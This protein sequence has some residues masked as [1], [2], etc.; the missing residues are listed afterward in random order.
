MVN[1][2]V[3]ESRGFAGKAARELA[4]ASHL[5]NVT[6]QGVNVR[7]RIS[8]AT[9]V[10]LARASDAER[11][12]R[13]LRAGPRPERKP[14]EKR[15]PRDGGERRFERSERPVS[16]RPERR[17][18][19]ASFGGER[20]PFVRKAEIPGSSEGERIAKRL[21]RAGI[22]SRRD[23]EELIAA[24]RVKVNGK[25]LRRQPSTSPPTIR[26]SWTAPPIPPIERTR[27]FLFHKPAGVVTTNRDPEGRKTVFDVLPE[28]LPRLMTI[29]RLDINTEGLAASHQRWRA[30]AGAGTSGDRLAAALPGAR[31]RQARTRRRWPALKDGIAVDGVFYGAIEATLDREQG[32][33]AWLTIGLREGKNRE[34]KNILGALGLEVIAA[35]PHFLRPVPA[36]RTAGRP[37]PGNQGQHAARPAR[38]AAD[39]GIGRE[40]RAPTSS[41]HSP[42]SRYAGANPS[43]K[44]SRNGR[45]SCA[46]ANAE[47]SARAA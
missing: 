10:R 37:R 32:T 20:K 45:K 4:I 44:N 35:D 26:S 39:R 33:N 31:P 11:A 6:R 27:L 9:T 8:S 30:G 38:R 47:G 3:R 29:G 40:F 15:P 41:S 25:V 21:A 23:A 42:T 34:V 36:R 13:P 17:A 24:G 46:T 43:A 16:D 7:V 18:K 1:A 2:R 14:F 5:S 12:D 22:A 28:D 19:P